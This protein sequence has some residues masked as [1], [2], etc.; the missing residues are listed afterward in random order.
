MVNS[1]DP[2]NNCASLHSYCNCRKASRGAIATIETTHRRKNFPT[3]FS[4]NPYSNAWTLYQDRRNLSSPPVQK[5]L[6]AGPSSASTCQHMRARGSF[7]S[8]RTSP[9]ESPTA[10]LQ[11]YVPGFLIQHLHHSLLFIFS[12]PSYT[13]R[14]IFIFRQSLTPL[15]PLSPYG[16]VLFLLKVLISL[17]L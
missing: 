7:S 13:F 8:R 16:V 1:S 10:D 12:P 14:F 4:D 15:K 11:A 9:P 5:S 6:A 3:R 2:S 17:L